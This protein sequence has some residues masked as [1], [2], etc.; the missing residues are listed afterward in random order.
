M[1]DVS[2]RQILAVTHADR[3][4]AAIW[5]DAM[6]TAQFDI[7]VVDPETM[8]RRKVPIRLSYM[9]P[10]QDAPPLVP[11][12]ATLSTMHNAAANGEIASRM[13]PELILQ[14]AQSAEARWIV[15]FAPKSEVMALCAGRSMT[16]LY[17]RNLAEYMFRTDAYAIHSIAEVIK[18]RFRMITPQEHMTIQEDT[19]GVLLNTHG[20]VAHA[21]DFLECQL[22]RTGLAMITTHLINTDVTPRRVFWTTVE[23]WLTGTITTP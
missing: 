15:P 12:T 2:I 13:G 11:T 9:P 22:S 21:A 3:K 4:W 23:P 6:R 19:F 7:R 1:S 17:I 5:V 20:V 14:M 8:I 10:S 18:N 16:D